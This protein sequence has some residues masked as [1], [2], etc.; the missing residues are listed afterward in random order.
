MV[1]VFKG[2]TGDPEEQGDIVR[3]VICDREVVKPV[4]VEIR[5]GQGFSLAADGDPS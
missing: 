4:L 5:D 2:T 1:A 3:L